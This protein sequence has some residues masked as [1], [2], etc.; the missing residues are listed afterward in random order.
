MTKNVSKLKLNYIFMLPILFRS[1]I[2]IFNTC[3]M[4]KN[5]KFNN[6]SFNSIINV[7]LEITLKNSRR[8]K[9]ETLPQVF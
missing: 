9:I 6:K 8:K 1:F 3:L 7:K 2:M 4:N 5:L